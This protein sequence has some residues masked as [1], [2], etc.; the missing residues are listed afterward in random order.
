[1][2]NI[3]CILK[4]VSSGS[5]QGVI[6]EVSKGNFG[7]SPSDTYDDCDRTYRTPSS[8]PALQNAAESGHL[9]IVK[10]LYEAA[11]QHIRDTGIKY[12]IQLSASNGHFDTVQY[13]L[14]SS[15]KTNT[16]NHQVSIGSLSRTAFVFGVQNGHLDIVKIG[17]QNIKE[18]EFEDKHYTFNI[19]IENAVKSIFSNTRYNEFVYKTNKNGVMSVIQYLSPMLKDFSKKPCST[20]ESSLLSVAAG[21]GFFTG[22]KYLLDEF[23]NELTNELLQKALWN[24]ALSKRASSA[25]ILI[26]HGAVLNEEICGSII[27]GGNMELV[28]Y[29]LEQGFEP[30]EEFINSNLAS[31][32]NNE[33]VRYLRKRLAGETDTVFG[34]GAFFDWLLK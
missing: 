22:L 8:W 30:T 19:F 16:K 27:Y 20:R 21:S 24:A 3:E 12:A 9:K 13:L 10:Y 31:P 5:L 17:L 23:N 14:N 6:D 28:K 34:V 7:Y 26:D 1:M 18:E 33:A 32:H 2:A 29:M 11:P 25:F 4:H 15:I